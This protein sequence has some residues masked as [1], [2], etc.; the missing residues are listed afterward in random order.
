MLEPTIKTPNYD[1][2]IS[3]IYTITEKCN[4]N[5][6]K[7]SYLCGSEILHPLF[8]SD[9]QLNVFLKNVRN[10]VQLTDCS[11]LSFTQHVLGLQIHF[12]TDLSNRQ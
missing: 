9:F 11:S 10:S 12:L 4:K 6:L 7:M 1:D 5:V 2:N 3:D 8:M